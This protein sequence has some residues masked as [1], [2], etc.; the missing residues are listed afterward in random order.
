VVRVEK[1]WGEGIMSRGSDIR[2]EFDE[3][4]GDYY[5]VWRPI[6]MGSGRTI[7]G[8]VEDLRKTAHFGIDILIDSKLRDIAAWSRLAHVRGAGRAR[9]GDWWRER[10]FNRRPALPQGRSRF[11]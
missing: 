1:D 2:I 3:A 8:A 11:R 6:V 7:R 4:S 5:G 9:A 10:G